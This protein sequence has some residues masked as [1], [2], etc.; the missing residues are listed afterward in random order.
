MAR[1]SKLHKWMCFAAVAIAPAGSA[2]AQDAVFT[3]DGPEK[4]LW[5]SEVLNR[6][7][8][9]AELGDL[10]VTLQ[11][12]GALTTKQVSIEKGETPTDVMIRNGV[13]ALVEKQDAAQRRR[14][15]VRSQY[16]YLPVR[17]QGWQR[18]DARLARAHAQ[19][20][21]RFA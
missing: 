19:P 6:D 1:F 11:T 3:Q 9:Q 13:A 4:F 7:D 12:N 18:L 5:R 17:P 20:A 2:G 21:G 15:A 8:V 10:Y 16:R 14:D